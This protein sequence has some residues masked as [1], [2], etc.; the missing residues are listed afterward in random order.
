MGVLRFEISN[1]PQP[2]T[3]SPQLVP[4]EGLAPSTFPF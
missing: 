2:I 1:T 3:P 4:R